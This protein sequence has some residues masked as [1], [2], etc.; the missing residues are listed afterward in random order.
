MFFLTKFALFLISPPQPSVSGLKDTLFD[1]YLLS[2]AFVLAVALAFIFF[3][4][5]SFAQSLFLT[6]ATVA[7]IV[8]ALGLV[9]VKKI[10]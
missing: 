4:I 8:F 9:S 7:A 1:V 6:L 2:D 10:P 5:L 3:C